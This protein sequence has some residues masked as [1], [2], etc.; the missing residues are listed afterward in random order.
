M[1]VLRNTRQEDDPHGLAAIA[2]LLPHGT[3]DDFE[4][5]VSERL[6]EIRRTRALLE[7]VKEF[8]PDIEFSPH[9]MRIQRIAEKHESARLLE[10]A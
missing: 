4:R 7:R 8:A 5:K 10:V 6:P 2:E 9:V 3:D 1:H